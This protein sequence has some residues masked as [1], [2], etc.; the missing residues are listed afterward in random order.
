MKE[1]TQLRAKLEAKR[2]LWKQVQAEWG[3]KEDRELAQVKCLGDLDEDA[4]IKAIKDLSDEI[5]SLEAKEA[6]LESIAQL[7]HDTEKK[8]S[9]VDAPAVHAKRTED[10]AEQKGYEETPGLVMAGMIRAAA[11]AKKTGM[12]PEDWC[13]KFGGSAIVAKALSSSIA[14]DGGVLVQGAHANDVIELL[15]AA[16][17]VRSLDP[18]ILPMDEG[19][20]TLPKHT[21]GATSYWIGENDAITESQPAFG[22]TKLIAKTVASLVPVSN[23]LLRR[24]SYAADMIV[25]DDMVAEL[26]V[27]MD[28]AF[29]RADG[30]NGK[31]KGLRY[32]AQAANVVNMTSTP[33]LAKVTSDLLKAI[34]RLEDSNV[35]LIRAGW[36]IA[37]RVKRY[38]MELRDGNG[39]FAFKDEMMTGKLFGYSFRSTTS[40]PTNLGGGTE[41]E[42]YFADFADVV[43]G[44]STG[45]VVDTS[46]EAAYVSGGS[47]I[48][49]FQNNQ[50]LVRAVMETDLAMRHAESVTVINACTWGA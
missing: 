20:M 7:E 35:K 21:A 4:K 48:S 41:T 26:G 38:L 22:E 49:A 18:R 45:I 25:R 40:I 12:S 2:A 1:L 17:A 34:Q 36:I 9:R 24:N 46:S 33:D 39:N 16:V 31:P 8:S 15:R 5:K 14:A 30:T 27:T 42:V 10:A 13:K 28:A 11:G 6:E 19:T 50:T 47:T 29:I 32:W 43:I 3:V 44:E 37:P 23:Q